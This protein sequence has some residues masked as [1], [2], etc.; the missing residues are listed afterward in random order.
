MGSRG[1]SLRPRVPSR[2]RQIGKTSPEQVPYPCATLCQSCGYLRE[3]AVEAGYR[4]LP[5]VHLGGA[6][7]ACGDEA[8]L[9]LRD[10]LALQILEEDDA[11]TSLSRRG[12]LLRWG[13]WAARGAGVL[14]VGGGGLV[15][16]AIVLRRFLERGSFTPW[17]ILALALLVGTIVFAKR[18]REVGLPQRVQSLPMRWRLALPTAQASCVPDP[19]PAVP[20]E[21]LVTAP[22]SGLPCVAYEVGVREDPDANANLGTWLL[23]EQGTA[24]LQVDHIGVP[25]DGARVR[26]SQRTR[27]D[28]CTQQDR[29]RKR[30]F[31]RERGFEDHSVQVF[32]TL[33][34]AG[35]ALVGRTEDG[36]IVVERAS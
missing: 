11:F 22:L 7:A 15:A 12:A 14:L 9:D 17:M 2:L 36:V 33:I 19:A 29:E 10:D 34:P 1:L 27:F 25:K 28:A 13:G 26:V 8:W 3:P 16:G 35:I 32:E 18:L 21:E 23:L 30:R 4:Q 31:L 6:C 20:G 24:P 5:D